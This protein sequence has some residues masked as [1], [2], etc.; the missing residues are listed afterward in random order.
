MITVG[1]NVTLGEAFVV[2][3]M[4]RQYNV[5]QAGDKSG[6]PVSVV[7]SIELDDEEAVTIG[8]IIALAAA[9]DLYLHVGLISQEPQ[10]LGVKT[11][12]TGK[13]TADE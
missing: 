12:I 11:E 4:R 7:E 13:E 10:L 5:Q 8:D 2:L 1:M 9:Y 6:L 3:R